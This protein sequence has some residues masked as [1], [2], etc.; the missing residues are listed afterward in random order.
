MLLLPFPLCTERS[1]IWPLV[2]VMGTAAEAL[3]ATIPGAEEAVAHVRQAAADAAPGPSSRIVRPDPSAPPELVE[4]L[5]LSERACYNPRCCNLASAS[6]AQLKGKLCTGCRVARFC[7][8]DCSKAV[9]KEHKADCKFMQ[10]M[11]REQAAADA[12]G[13]GEGEGGS[14]PSA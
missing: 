2:R 14:S 9:W 11:R 4:L 1:K 5:G 13:E 7:C 6:E 12:A 3:G 10:R 8:M